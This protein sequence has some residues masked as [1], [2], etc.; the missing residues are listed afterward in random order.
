MERYGNAADPCFTCRFAVCNGKTATQEAIIG[1]IFLQ[2]G[3]EDNNNDMIV[4]S[5]N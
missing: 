1:V 2:E 3:M 5:K 4:I